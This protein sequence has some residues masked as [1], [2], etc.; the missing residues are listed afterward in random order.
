MIVQYRRMT[1]QELEY[2]SVPDT[3]KKEEDEETLM[4]VYIRTKAVYE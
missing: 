4:Q 2:S 3:Q 1:R